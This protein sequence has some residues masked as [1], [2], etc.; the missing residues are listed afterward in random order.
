MLANVFGYGHFERVSWIDVLVSCI[1]ISV[2][3]V[4][5]RKQ[6]AREMRLWLQAKRKQARQ[7]ASSQSEISFRLPP[8]FELDAFLADMATFYTH[9]YQKKIPALC[10]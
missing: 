1:F 9:L 6:N 8:G 7:E 10:V 3:V 5:R 2:M 4:V